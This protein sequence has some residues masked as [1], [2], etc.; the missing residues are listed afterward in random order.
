MRPL[1]VA[2]L[3]GAGWGRLAPL[4]PTDGAVYAILFIAIT[5]LF[6]K[7]C[8]DVGLQAEESL[9]GAVSGAGGAIAGSRLFFLITTG[10]LVRTSPAQWVN[11]GGGTASWGAYLGGIAGLATFCRFS[12]ASFWVMAD[13]GASCAGLSEVIGRWA[14]LLAGDDF[15]R[16]STLPWA[17]H[18]PPGSFAYRAHAARG[19]LEA[20]A[21]Q[22][23][24]VHPLQIYLMLN[25]AVVF[26]L[27]TLAWRRW[28]N[29]PGRTLATFLLLHGATRFCW[30]FLRDPDAGGARGLLSVSQ[31]TCL[32]MVA[33]G[34]LLAIRLRGMRSEVPAAAS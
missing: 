34:V 3:V 7:R 17:I 27:T 6:L 10:A 4:V 29:A 26:A 13:V 31:W 22:S 21:T 12:S 32:G 20:G 11:L 5:L 15:G 8:G 18:F 1:L 25:A 30:E 28:R 9:G 33:A 19:L 16:V 23:L 24:A 2:H 14:C